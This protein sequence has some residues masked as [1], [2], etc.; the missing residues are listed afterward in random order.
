MKAMTKM[1]EQMVEVDS[2]LGNRMM[3]R[4]A[5]V[6]MWKQQVRALHTEF[7]GSYAAIESLVE[8]AGIKAEDEFLRLIRKQHN[9]VVAR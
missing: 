5:Y 2:F 4:T 9:L 1:T 8:L 6:S 7:S 3:T